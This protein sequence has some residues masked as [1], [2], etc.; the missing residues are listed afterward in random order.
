[1]SQLT[2]KKPALQVNKL[3][4]SGR[5]RDLFKLW[6]VNL[7]LAIPTLGIYR[8]WA[9]AK[10]RRYQ[11]AHL[12]LGNDFFEHTGT[13]KELFVGFAKVMGLFFLIY[14]SYNFLA[15]L[16]FGKAIVLVTAPLLYIAVFYLMSVAR[17]ASVRYMA[18]RTTWQGVRG[19]LGGSAFSYANF[20]LIRTLINIVTLGLKK[21]KSDVLKHKFIMDNLQFG[22]QKFSFHGTSKG[23]MKPFLLQYLLISLPIIA[24]IL[25]GTA[26]NSNE[27]SSST[28]TRNDQNIQSY[29][30]SSYDQHS[31]LH[32]A[33]FDGA[34]RTKY[35]S[36]VIDVQYNED[37]T[38]QSAD[39]T[40]KVD[41]SAVILA[42]LG[43]FLGAGMLIVFLILLAFSA[44]FF[45]ITA[46]YKV[47]LTRKKFAGLSLGDLRFKN[48]LTF[49]SYIGLVLGNLV[50]AL[51][52]LT[53]GTALVWK[54]NMQFM[55]RYV[56]IGGDIDSFSTKQVELQ[57][58]SVGEGLGDALDLDAGFDIGL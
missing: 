5:A 3:I 16:P 6:L 2:G 50:I 13:G 10:I 9:K 38:P 30:G 28:K 12:K 23:L 43:A 15:F 39:K 47:A 32:L 20:A 21:P 7:L 55:A 44:V 34:T 57:K 26:F 48:K 40:V 51:F 17:Y 29:E 11:S 49:A 18:S 36:H 4:Y 42:A 14:M 41:P 27:I 31:L 53:L 19:R 58:A 1:M 56:I 54:R 45:I 24:G 35:D 37:S 8:F 46:P 33:S 25:M 22:A 52:T